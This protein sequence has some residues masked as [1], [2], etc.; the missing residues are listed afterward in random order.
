MDGQRRAG[1][2]EKG[3]HRVDGGSLFHDVQCPEVL[4]LAAVKLLA[5]QVVDDFVRPAT[6]GGGRRNRPAQEQ[7]LQKR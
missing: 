5:S 2:I 4:G 6:A 1:D 3:S 7:E